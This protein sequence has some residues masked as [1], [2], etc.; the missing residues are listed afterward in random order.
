MKKED[1]LNRIDGH[2]LILGGSGGIGVEVVRAL[3]AHG[4]SAITIAYG[5]NQAAADAL[6]KDVTDAIGIPAYVAQLSAPKKDAQVADYEAF[7]D[8]VVAAAGQEISVMV[9]TIGISPNRRHEDQTIEGKDG[10]EDVFA[11][12]VHS[13][14]LTT[15]ASAMRMAAKGVRGSITIIT[16]TN[17]I[18]SQAEYSVHY[19]ASKAA[20]AHMVRTLAEPYARKYGIRLNGIAPG[21][22]DTGMNDTLPPGEYE[23]ELA[24]IWLGSAPI[25]PAEVGK[26]VAFVAGTGGAYITG[27]NIIIDG[28]YR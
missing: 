19:D 6:A 21:W 9:N 13:V 18:N 1:Y 14:F 5:R 3:A 12:N 26:L 4:P 10:W 28:G 16:S 27:Q 7:L 24:K 11:T 17:G 23:K 2:A 8:R 25:P 22:I 20:L 15:R